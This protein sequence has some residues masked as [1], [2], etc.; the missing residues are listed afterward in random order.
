MFVLELVKES[1][2]QSYDSE[3]V[4]KDK[5]TL[6]IEHVGFHIFLVFLYVFQ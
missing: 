2:G 4:E 1:Y 5:L 6:V 3:N